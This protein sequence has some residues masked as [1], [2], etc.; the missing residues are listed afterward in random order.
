MSLRALLAAER[1]RQRRS[2][3]RAA[4]CAVAV[5]ASSILLLGLSGWFITASAIA[6]AL[7]SLGASAFNYMLPS[8]GIRLLAI[9]RTAGRYGERLAGHQ[10]AL[11][12]LARIRAAVFAA[13]AAAPAIEG[14]AMRTG[15]A[16]ARLIQDVEAVENG[17]IRLSAP[18]AL[19]A[20]IVA[21]CGLML[22]AG[23][24]AALAAVAILGMILFLADH[25]ARLSAERGRA[26]QRAAGEMKAQAETL[27]HAAAELR[28]FGLEDWSEWRI[29]DAGGAFEHAR[30]RQAATEAAVELIQA[31]GIGLAVALVLLLGADPGAPRAAMAALAAAMM[32][33]GAA[34]TIRAFT[35][36]SKLTEA[37]RRLDEILDIGTGPEGHF[38]PSAWHLRLGDTDQSFM[39][40]SRVLLDG[41]SGAGKTT[42]I[43]ILLGLRR[44]PGVAWVDGGDVNRVPPQRLRAG[45]A[46]LPQDAALIAGTV[47]D[48]LRLAAPDTDEISLW[49]ALHDAALDQVVT[50]MPEGLDTW[51]GEDGTR[52]SGGERRRL[53]LA[54]AY[55][56]PAPWLVLDEPSEGLDAATEAVVVRRLRARLK[57]SGQGLVLASHRP[58]LAALADR[59]VAVGQAPIAAAA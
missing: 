34:P 41:P 9:V 43:E 18:W 52:L 10:A 38:V 47:R 32:V 45:F 53:A 28:C 54:R 24:T 14:T 11:R 27:A 25:V 36:R 6:G 13:L 30:R 39:P 23:W 58:T 48:N 22:L 33:D 49:D 17:F 56:S 29:C 12:A 55:L 20:A 26:V 46:W 7:G 37:T 57:R 42:L 59:C 31:A 8:A 16:S 1:R 50:A 3:R 15:D 35:Q 51:I 44:A 5:A 21:G 2:V 4:L 40:G 19:L